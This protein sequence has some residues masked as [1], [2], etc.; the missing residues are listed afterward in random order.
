MSIVL[1]F[2][3]A[4]GVFLL[5]F[6]VLPNRRSAWR[7]LLPGAFAAATGFLV[8]QFIGGFYVTRVVK[9]ASESYGVFAV[10]IGLLSW[11]HLLAQVVLFAA[12]INVVRD[13]RLWPRSLSGDNLT[14][15]DTRALCRFAKAAER[16]DDE[17]ISMT[18]V[19]RGTSP[20]TQ[21][22]AERPSLPKQ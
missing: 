19:G 21:P 1:A 9:G 2:V 5:A 17:D 12:E 18:L 4:T 15:A 7:A 3:L 16:R 20:V 22:H 10:V 6:Q 8:L 11:I 14:A 13:E